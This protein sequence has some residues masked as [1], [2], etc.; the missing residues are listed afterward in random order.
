MAEPLT[1]DQTASAL[2]E[3][4]W[5]DDWLIGL[6]SQVF[7]QQLQQRSAEL[8][9]LGQAGTRPTV[10]IATADPLA[11]LAGFFAASL[12][13]L[14]VF[15]GNPHW[16][17]RE[18]QQAMALVRPGVVMGG[19]VEAG[20]MGR[21][22]EGKKGPQHGPTI[23]IPTG[24][25]SGQ[26]KFVLHRWDTLMASVQGFRQYF[27][28]PAVNAYC[29]LPLFHVS[30]LMQAL[31]VLATGGTLAVQPYRALKQGTILE[32]P[33]NPKFLSLVP[34]QL[35]H[36]LARGGDYIPWLRGFRAVLLG[37]APAWPSLLEQARSLAIPLALTYGMSETASQVATLLPEDFLQGNSSSGRA[38]PQATLQ[39]LD[40]QGQPLLA[41]SPGRVQIQATSL[42]QG[43]LSAPPIPASPRPPLASGFLTDD[44][45]YLDPNGYLHILGRHSSMIIT[46][47]ENVFP[48]EVEA[49]LL[50]MGLVQDVCVLG[51]PDPQWGE[52][53]T[54]M[55]VPSRSEV[56]PE[57]LRQA[58]QPQL[59]AYKVPKQWLRV[60]AIPRTV[61]GKVNRAEAKRLALQQLVDSVVSAETF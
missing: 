56:A 1:P 41:N 37:G 45:G 16:G 10:L 44:I 61:Q 48:E 47:G 29:V 51:L 59:A 46:G 55:V 34:T 18:W 52:R 25:T 4:R 35:Q 15:L 40:D 57:T 22:G 8:E 33:G 11:C 53:V 6:D 50:A 49:T 58:L 3:Q 21:Q 9:D 7:W 26:L 2:L 39:I 31:R 23:G 12:T 36:M 24:G 19:E 5:G 17:E 28:S 30:G 20:E 54:A 13:G 27:G 43:Y 32:L 38:L 42:A 60:T 14:P